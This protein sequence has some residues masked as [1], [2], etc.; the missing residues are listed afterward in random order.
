MTEFNGDIN[1]KKFPDT[2]RALNMNKYMTLDN[3]NQFGSKH[4]KSTLDM[5]TKA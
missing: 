1:Q 2:H 5:V 4:A 3:Q